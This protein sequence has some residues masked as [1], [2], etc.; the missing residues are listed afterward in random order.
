MR[1]VWETHEGSSTSS[2]VSDDVGNEEEFS[3]LGEVRGRKH[4]I[5]NP[6]YSCAAGPFSIW[7]SR[8]YCC[9]PLSSS[10]RERN[11]LSQDDIFLL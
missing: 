8:R 3:S 4:Q 6:H 10:G 9:V 7:Y 11:A 1:L 5:I 2:D